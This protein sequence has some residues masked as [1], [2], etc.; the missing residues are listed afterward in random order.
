MTAER[1]F[2]VEIKERV[3]DWKKESRIKQLYDGLYR[4]A[5]NK[6]DL[7]SWRTMGVHLSEILGSPNPEWI[8]PPP[9]TFPEGVKL[10][11]KIIGGTSLAPLKNEVL[12]QVYGNDNNIDMFTP[13]EK[14]KPFGAIIFSARH[15]PERLAWEVADLLE[16]QG[17]EVAVINPVGHYPDGQTR[18]IGPDL[19]TRPV[20]KA[21]FLSSTQIKDGGSLSVLLLTQRI[22]RHPNLSFMIDE[23]IIVIPMFGG[24]RGHKPGQRKEIGYEVLQAIYDP[25]TLANNIRDIEECIFDEHHKTAKVYPHVL[26]LR[27]QPKFPKVRFLSV[28]IHNNEL[29]RRKF[30][31]AG[32]T[33]TSASPAQEQAEELTE[34]LEKK[35]LTELP[36]YLVCCDKGSRK[37]TSS[38]ARELLKLEKLKKIRILFMNKSRVRAGEVENCQLET[39]VECWLE[40]GE[41]KARSLKLA[42]GD[43][44]KGCIIASIDDMIDTGGTAEKDR[45]TVEGIFTNIVSSFFLAT[46]AVCSRGVHGSLNKIGADHYLIGNSLNPEGL[47]DPRVQMVNLAA[48]IA[49]NL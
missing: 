40:N 30:T 27:G 25:K 23:V 42:D 12:W 18:I 36:L 1:G 38:I 26:A 44:K 35:K 29:P 32:F 4:G 46:H 49:R 37:R 9:E 13:K 20:K 31:E 41:I 28:D 39:V 6:K 8:S 3:K 48:A 11:D 21:I 10:I 24:S 43:R 2:L 15:T 14:T 45:K 16:S 34:I 33:F 19:L 17:Q 47:D 5:R 7:V 22:L